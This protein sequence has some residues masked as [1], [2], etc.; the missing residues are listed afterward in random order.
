MAHV[1]VG[2]WR[3]GDR[4]QYGNVVEIKY[5]VEEDWGEGRI[6]VASDKFGCGEI[7]PPFPYEEHRHQWRLTNIIFFEE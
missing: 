7:E 4:L 5:G 2:T 6:E 3:A 1:S